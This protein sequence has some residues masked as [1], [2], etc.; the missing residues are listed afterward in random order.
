MPLSQFAG[1]VA[2]LGTLAGVGL[3][4]AAVFRG[5]RAGRPRVARR[6]VERQLGPGESRVPRVVFDLPK[7]RTAPLLS[8][9]AGAPPETGVEGVLLGDEDSAL[10]RPVLLALAPRPVR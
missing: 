1:I 9:K 7:G 6:T 10:R 2:L 3:A 5:W 8:A 4:A